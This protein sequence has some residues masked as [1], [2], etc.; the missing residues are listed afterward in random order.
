[1][2]FSV[3]KI[4]QLNAIERGPHPVGNL[5]VV[6]KS[7]GLFSQNGSD[8]Q[9]STGSMGSTEARFFLLRW[10]ATLN[11]PKWLY[12]VI[13]IPWTLIK[14]C[15][16]QATV[17]QNRRPDTASTRCGGGVWPTTCQTPQKNVGSQLL[18]VYHIPSVNRRLVVGQV[19]TVPGAWRLVLLEEW[20]RAG[21]NFCRVGCRQLRWGC[22]DEMSCNFAGMNIHSI[23]LS[24]IIYLGHGIER[25]V[26]LWCVRMQ[27]EGCY[28]CTPT[29]L[30]EN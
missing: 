29:I 17:R 22:V 8:E 20:P 14:V 4:N 16:L 27:L 1:M 11:N 6:Q 21:R 30:N 3:T 18:S 25:K 24:A 13:Y 5:C 7:M 28:T 2:V 12:N 9:G 10:G 26:Q 19:W 23:H 15:G